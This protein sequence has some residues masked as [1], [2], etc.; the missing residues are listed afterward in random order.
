MTVIGIK[1]AIQSLAQALQISSIFPASLLIFVNAYFIV[2]FVFNVDPNSLRLST[3]ALVIALLLSYIL[4][5]YNFQIIRIFEGYR[6][7]DSK[8]VQSLRSNELAKFYSLIHEM[9][10][11]EDIRFSF[12]ELLP[13]TPENVDSISIQAL[14]P[15]T[16]NYYYRWRKAVHK[17]AVLRSQFEYRFPSNPESVLATPLGNVIAAFEDYPRTRYGIDPIALWPRLVPTLKDSDFIQYVIQEKSAFD[18]LL[19]FQIVS[20]ILGIELFCLNMYLDQKWLA[21]FLLAVTF[22][23]IFLLY[24]G[25]IL[26][27]RQW[28]LTV[29]VAFDLH[30]YLLQQSLGLKATNSFQTDVETWRNIS[31]F[32]LH[33]QSAKRGKDIFVSSAHFRKTEQQK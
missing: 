9:Q 30:R 23:T 24:R 29:R 21:L 17:S 14:D 13:F 4:Y 1:D 20:L 19:N 22:V 10:Q 31:R 2:P 33:R 26:A 25:M 15:V 11:E 28:G 6:W 27:A 5:V 16:A 18:F 7:A 32:I 8:I 12:E 3:T